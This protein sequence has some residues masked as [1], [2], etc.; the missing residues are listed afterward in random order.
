[1]PTLFPGSTRGL[2]FGQEWCA[3]GPPGSCRPWAAC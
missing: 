3:A 2:V 1:L